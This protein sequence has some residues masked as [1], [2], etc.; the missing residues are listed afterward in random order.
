[1]TVLKIYRIS[2]LMLV[3]L[4]FLAAGMVV[5]I[6]FVCSRHWRAKANAGSTMLWS[7]AMCCILGI[8][9]VKNGAVRDAGGFIVCNHISYLD[10]FVLGS[11]MPSAF[12]SKQEVR[13]WPLLGWLA[14]LGGTIF[15]NRESKREALNTMIDIEQKIDSG[16]AVIIFPE[17]TTSDGRE[18][19]SFKSTFFK[20]PA[21]RNMP[22]TPV[23]IRYAHPLID[24]VAWYGG[25]ELAPHFWKIVGFRRIEALVHFSS[26][27]TEP[28]DE[29]SRMEARKRLCARAHESVVEGF[30][31]CG[32]M[33]R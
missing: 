18:I 7:R 14:L 31:A 21:T 13:G 28:A 30:N 5:N 4:A 17:G 2:L 23:S 6:L 32:T 26:P 8:Q 19:K 3:N 29:V 1:M 15:V 12:L 20:V 11:L 22:V 27:I 16:I 9:V 24:E 33:E 25:M 10:I